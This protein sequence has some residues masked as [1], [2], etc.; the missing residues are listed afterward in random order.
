M[1]RNI[2][3]THNLPSKKLESDG[4]SETKECNY[5]I[6]KHFTFVSPRNYLFLDSGLGAFL[7]LNSPIILVTDYM[8]DLQSNES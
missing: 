3:N 2:S 8:L 5:H 6:P 1:I 7:Q 4:H